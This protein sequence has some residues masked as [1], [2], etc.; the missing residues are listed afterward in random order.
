MDSVSSPNLSQVRNGGMQM[1]GQVN[2]VLRGSD[3]VGSINR[4]NAQISRTG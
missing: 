3:L 4:T 1:G 2:L